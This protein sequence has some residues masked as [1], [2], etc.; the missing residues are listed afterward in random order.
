MRLRRFHIYREFPL[1]RVAV[2]SWLAAF[3]LLALFHCALPEDRIGYGPE[4]GKGMNIFFMPPRNAFNSGDF[5][6]SLDKLHSL[7]VNTLFLVPYYFSPDQASDR[8]YA[9]AKTIPDS[10]LV[11]AITLGREQGFAVVLKPHI[12]L[13]NGEPRFK[14]VP[15]DFAAWLANY[16]TF[17]LHY[18]E[19]ARSEDLP[20]FVIG[21]ELDGVS[22]RDGFRRLCDSLRG[23][24]PIRLTYAAS[25]D[26]FIG[27]GIWEHVDRMG[28]NAYFNLDNNRP[29]SRQALRETWN[30]WLNL[31]STFASLKGMPV[32]FTEVG[33]FS[34]TTAA[35]NLGDWSG[36][37]A[38]DPDLQGECYAALLSQAWEFPAIKGIAWW[39]WE[40]GG[41]GGL[42]N[43]D[44]TP[45]D[46]PAENVIRSYW[47]K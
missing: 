40:L 38:P 15:T 6:E 12:D 10:Q 32:I 43:N 18:L 35:K 28:I 47:T 11:R 2:Y 16:K 4:Y 33:Y 46:K 21:T 25:F 45:R 7:G 23:T 42:E 9:T 8:I 26:H 13:E 14:I 29:P 39:Q 34:R 19:I 20:D 31:V 3:S 17:I 1:K 30:Y 27:T 5:I 44:A 41:I 37:K 22:E 36:N 24:S